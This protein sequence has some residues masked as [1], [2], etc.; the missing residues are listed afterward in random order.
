MH[1]QR[2]HSRLLLHNQ[3]GRKG[4]SPEG[5]AEPARL[6]RKGGEA[7]ASAFGKKVPA[8]AQDRYGLSSQAITS[9][10]W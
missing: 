7:S 10:S 5:G 4:H 6:P 9:Q 1:P 2:P 3:S 8:M